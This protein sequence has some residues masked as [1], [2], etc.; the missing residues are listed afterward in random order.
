MPR[1]FE[2]LFSQL[3]DLRPDGLLRGVHDLQPLAFRLRQ[4]L[5]IRDFGNE[6]GHI[7]SKPFCHFILGHARILNYVV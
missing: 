2:I 7:G 5:V 1:R 6:I 4:R 3:D